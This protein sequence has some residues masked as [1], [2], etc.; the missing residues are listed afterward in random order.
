MYS[1]SIEFGNL[2]KE[3]TMSNVY[4]EEIPG[5]PFGV[6]VLPD[7]SGGYRWFIAQGD[8]DLADNEFIMECQETYSTPYEA[9]EA[10]LKEAAAGYARWSGIFETKL[11]EW[12]SN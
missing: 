4:Y 6:L 7:I 3:T 9:V 5:T 8:V 1:R 2:A 11:K 12:V 10:A